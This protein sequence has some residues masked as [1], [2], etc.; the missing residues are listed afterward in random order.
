MFWSF[1]LIS[2]LFQSGKSSIIHMK[3]PSHIPEY[4]KQTKPNCLDS[5][6]LCSRLNSKMEIKRKICLG[7]HTKLILM[8]FPRRFPNF[9][10]VFNLFHPLNNVSHSKTSFQI[11]NILKTRTYQV[12]TSLSLTKSRLEVLF[13]PHL[14]LKSFTHLVKVFHDVLDDITA[15]LE[16]G[17]DSNNTTRR[18]SL[19][20]SCLKVAECQKKITQIEKRLTK[21]FSQT[22]SKFF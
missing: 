4:W 19:V 15:R 17:T 20:K 12:F 9:I 22:F 2:L 13:P 3:L 21:L 1:E 5:L 8:S 6:Y 11:L 18:Q 14:E 16:I 7:N 10:D